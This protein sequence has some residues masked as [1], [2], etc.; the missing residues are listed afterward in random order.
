MLRCENGALGGLQ[1]KSS[2]QENVMSGVKGSSHDTSVK[3]AKDWTKS[4]A[5]VLD[6]FARLAL[7]FNQTD[8]AKYLFLWASVLTLKFAQ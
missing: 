7:C 6:I 1:S 5:A 3:E 4:W 8:L 2:N